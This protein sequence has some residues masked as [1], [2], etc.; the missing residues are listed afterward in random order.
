M[1]VL[2]PSSYKQYGRIRRDKEKSRKKKMCPV[3]ETAK[4]T[5]HLSLQND[6]TGDM[7][8]ACTFV[9]GMK[10]VSKN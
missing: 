6:I 3:L 4:Y 8:E 1:V 9:S 10:K 7:K 5:R 2:L